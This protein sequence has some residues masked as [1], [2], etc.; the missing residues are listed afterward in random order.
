MKELAETTIA[1]R[2]QEHEQAFNGYIGASARIRRIFPDRLA[3]PHNTAI[4][5]HRGRLNGDTAASVVDLANAVNDVGAAY[6]HTGAADAVNEVIRTIEQRGTSGLV[7]E[8]NRSVRARAAA[9]RR[10]YSASQSQLS[11][12]MIPYSMG[13]TSAYT[14]RQKLGLPQVRGAKLGISGDCGCAQQH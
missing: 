6:R 3:I 13:F 1:Q 7:A 4:L 12:A 11:S 2:E 5:R 10:D 14:A 8:L 9:W